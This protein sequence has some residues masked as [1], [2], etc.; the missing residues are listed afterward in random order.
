MRCPV[1]RYRDP[2]DL[3][4]PRG[5]RPRENQAPAVEW[6]REPEVADSPELTRVLALPRRAPLGDAVERAQQL[7]ELVTARH[8]RVDDSDCRCAE[9]RPDQ[10]CILSLNA[11]QA[12]ALHEISVVGGLCGEMGVGVGKTLLDVLAPMA[13]ADHGVETSVLLVPPKLQQQLADEHLLLSQHWVVPSIRIEAVGYAPTFRDRPRLVVLPYSQLSRPSCST[14]LE[15][16]RP[17]AVIAD[18]AHRLRD[19]KTSTTM[20]VDRYLREHPHV[21]FLWWTGTPTDSKI[22]DYAHLSRWALG[23]R[24]PVPVA[25]DVAQDWGRAL[26][27]RKTCAGPGALLA[28]CEPGEHV[29]EGFRRRRA[30]TL[31]V[32]MTVQPSWAGELVIGVAPSPEI[33]PVIRDALD[34]LRRTATRPDGEELVDAL[35]VAASARELACGFYHRWDFPR[36]RGPDAVEDDALIDAW[37]AARRAWHRELRVKVAR[38]EPQL[39]SPKLARD[40][41]QRHWGDRPRDKRLPTWHSD[42][43]PAWRAIAPLVR[44]VPEVEWLSDFL[45]EAAAEWAL[46]HRGVVW[47]SLTAFGAAVERLTRLPRF[48]A[49]PL[50]AR[51]LLA[52]RGDRSVIASTLAHGVGTNGLQFRFAS[53]LLAQHGA[54]NTGWEQTLGRLA[55]PGQRSPRVD[56]LF[57]AHTPELRAAYREAHRRAEYVQTSGSSA[58]KLAYGSDDEALAIV[59]EGETE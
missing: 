3:V 28:W 19:P 15:A 10:A 35:A 27:A 6:A 42:A 13:L 21:K 26:N 36:S 40:A 54:S 1:T 51:G 46:S 18:E 24:S 32:V 48:G 50:A 29:R 23:K 53:Q 30:E 14:Y 5:H 49:G 7:V 57:F 56:A 33:P 39:D 47:Y 8:R 37:F 44:P 55:R 2:S 52:E 16:L 38:G 20:R 4:A 45:A 12:W 9:L 43:W 17:D 34:A 59:S 22:E 41:A 25:L 58:Q 31:G 11:A